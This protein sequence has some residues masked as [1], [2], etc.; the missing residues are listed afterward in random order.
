[1]SAAAGSRSRRDRHRPTVRTAAPDHRAVRSTS[2][3]SPLPV[4]VA[5]MRNGGPKA[6][7]REFA[8]ARADQPLR[9]ERPA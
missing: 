3:P 6:A 4:P 5:E 7:V 2:G 1:M 9:I 8:V